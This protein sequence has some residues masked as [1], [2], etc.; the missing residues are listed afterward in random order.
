MKFI[1]IDPGT[2]RTGFAYFKDGDPV[3]VG[4]I[5]VTGGGPDRVNAI[6]FNIEKEI[7]KYEIDAVVCEEPVSRYKSTSILH[8]LFFEIRRYAKKIKLPFYSYLPGQVKKYQGKSNM[9]KSVMAAALSQNYG[10]AGLTEDECDAV[11]L[12]LYHAGI[13]KMQEL[14]DESNNR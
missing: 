11:A 7:G 9:P 13:I 10:I 12:G 5:E 14:A 4:H 1:A 8:V 3:E 2:Y 6:V